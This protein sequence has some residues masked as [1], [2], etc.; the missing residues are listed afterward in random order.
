MNY[1]GGDI[2]ATAQIYNSQWYNDQIQKGFLELSLQTLPSN[3]FA[4]AMVGHF[5]SGSEYSGCWGLDPVGSK[6]DLKIAI[7]TYVKAA[8]DNATHTVS[9]AITFTSPPLVLLQMG[10][11]NAPGNIQ[12]RDGEMV[13]KITTTG[14]VH[15]SGCTELSHMC[16]IA[17]GW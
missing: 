7:G 5:I 11:G 3:G 2:M 1:L 17:I 9:F 8:G 15:C 10:T 13:G 16:Y 4:G 12:Y 6:K 14:F